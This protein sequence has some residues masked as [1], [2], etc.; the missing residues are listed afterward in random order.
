MDANYN[1]LQEISDTQ[2]ASLLLGDSA[3]ISSDTFHYASPWEVW[4]SALQLRKELGID[5]ESRAVAG[6]DEDADMWAAA[7]DEDDDAYQMVGGD[8]KWTREQAPHPGYSKSYKLDDGTDIAVSVSEHYRFRGSRLARFN[9]MEWESCVDVVPMSAEEKEKRAANL[10][11]LAAAESGKLPLHNEELA[12]VRRGA[13]PSGCFAFHAAHPLVNTHWQRMRTKVHC[14]KHGGGK[15]PPREPTLGGGSDKDRPVSDSWRQKRELFSEYMAANFVPWAVSSDD[16]D[17]KTEDQNCPPDLSSDAFGTWMTLLK[18]A[19]RADA[20]SSERHVARGRLFELGHYVHALSVNKEYKQCLQQTR[21]RNRT[22]WPK[23]V[24]DALGERKKTANKSVEEI[25]ALRADA[26][27]KAFNKKQA[28]S[29]RQTSQE[30]LNNATEMESFLTRLMALHGCALPPKDDT[31]PTADDTTPTADASAPAYQEMA[32]A[33]GFLPVE[34]LAGPN[35]E[36]PVEELKNRHEKLQRLP[37]Q[38][39]TATPDAPSPLPNA[40]TG[41]PDAFMA[42]G[43]VS[44]EDPPELVY[45]KDE[46]CALEPLLAKWELEKEAAAA[47]D[48]PLEEPLPPL[49]NEQRAAGREILNALRELERA[50]RRKPWANRAEWMEGLDKVQRLFFLNGAAGT[51]KTALIKTLDV[52]MQRLGLGQMLLSAFTGTAVVELENA[53]TTLTLFDIP[54]YFGEGGL[55]AIKSAENIIRFETFARLPPNEHDGLRL[56]VLDE[57]SFIP[58]SLLHHVSERLE[59]LLARDSGLHFGG[60]VFVAAGDFHQKLP[61][62]KPSLHKELLAANGVS[63]PTKIGTVPPSKKASRNPHHGKQATAGGVALFAKFRRLCLTVNNRFKKDPDWGH[64]LGQMR[65]LDH[66]TPV[67]AEFREA[68][69]V[70]S[71]SEKRDPGWIFAPIGVVSNDERHF[72][73]AAQAYRWAQHHRLPLVRWKLPVKGLERLEPA[74]LQGLYEEEPSLWGYFVKGAAAVLTTDNLSQGRGLVNG[75][76]IVLDS[77]TMDPKLGLDIGA[78]LRQAGPGGVV[79]L[80]H[81]PFS[82]QVRPQVKPVFLERL[83]EFSVRP[84]ECVI[85]ILQGEGELE[86]ELTSRYAVATVGDRKVALKKT[87]LIELGFAFTDYKM[88]GKTVDRLVLSLA[89]RT[90]GANIELASVYVLASRVRARAGVRVLCADADNFEH[91]SRLRPATELAVWDAAYDEFGFFSALKAADAALA[92]AGRLAALHKEEKA[93]AAASKKKPSKPAAR[94]QRRWKLPPAVAKQTAAELR[95]LTKQAT[96]TTE[97]TF[98]VHEDRVR[99]QQTQSTKHAIKTAPLRSV[100]ASTALAPSI[101][102]LQARFPSRADAQLNTRAPAACAGNPEV[103]FITHALRRLAFLRDRL[104]ADP[105]V[106]VT[107]AGRDF[108]SSL[109]KDAKGQWRAAYGEQGE[110]ARL[111]FLKAFEDALARLDH[112]FPGRVHYDTLPIRPFSKSHYQ[113]FGANLEN[114]NLPHGESFVGAGGVAAKIGSQELGV[115]G[116]IT[117]PLRGDPQQLTEHVG[118]DGSLSSIW[119]ANSCH[120]DSALAALEAA[121]SAASEARGQ[122]QLEFCRPLL[123]HSANPSAPNAPAPADVASPLLA[124]FLAR[125]RI[126]QSS[127]ATQTDIDAMQVARDEAR[128]AVERAVALQATQHRNSS[129]DTIA[130]VVKAR[131]DQTSNVMTNLRYLLGVDSGSAPGAPRSYDALSAQDQVICGRC[132]QVVRDALCDR[133]RFVDVRAF[134]SDGG[135]PLATFGRMLVGES[136]RHEI[137]S[138]DTVDTSGASHDPVLLEENFQPCATCGAAPKE[139]LHR[140]LTEIEQPEVSR[141][142]LLVVPCDTNVMGGSTCSTVSFGDCADCDK[143]AVDL[144]NGSGVRYYQL[145]AVIQF[146]GY[147]YVADVRGDGAGGPVLNATPWVR[148]DGMHK[149]YPCAQPVQPP[150]GAMD[151][152]GYVPACA[153]YC[154]VDRAPQPRVRSRRRQI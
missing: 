19:A 13:R 24:A 116:I 3:H 114:F 53:M 90:V 49:N 21:M 42:T 73:N 33:A 143:Y 92:V 84:G 122:P 11:R 72:L 55:G 151:A 96:K 136:V 118:V 60:V 98:T 123:V 57:L 4:E 81:Q 51:G 15:S 61:V 63:V 125:A 38:Q 54:F 26:E 126:A 71:D 145:V 39:L 100:L 88:Q 147:H 75:T 112:G 106:V 121:F 48:P 94:R 25:E 142:P 17:I 108:E 103:P 128:A 40:P 44:D 29:Q 28:R 43:V 110:P 41:A 12:E 32:A 139:F 9:Y 70:L 16:D 1:A 99:D 6:I 78:L 87:H 95:Q 30:A 109:G 27:L 133:K 35:I 132:G 104:R 65:K 101:S 153:M 146:N 47:A 20:N 137:E 80:K 23:D 58:P 89:H 131:M 67:G 76:R 8:S 120:I 97:Q 82:I 117:T 86:K 79:T 56:V 10:G 68:L 91:L 31:T 69:R 66:P 134:H 22:Q 62:A 2:A 107:V 138:M 50:K 36:D 18:E 105:A 7:D 64:I 113:V 14:L 150:D 83:R 115:F 45:L 127:G 5:E 46:E 152:K 93:A 149:P 85:P 135:N 102:N 140:P 52:L 144:P 148:L 37:T 124:W 154:E 129:E 141:P 74:E 59:W 77:I 130:S 119:S 111:R 34:S